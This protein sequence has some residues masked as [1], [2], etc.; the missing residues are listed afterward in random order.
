MQNIQMAAAPSAVTPNLFL[1]ILQNTLYEMQSYLCVLNVLFTYV[2]YLFRRLYLVPLIQ[3]LPVSR[4]VRTN[5]SAI[6]TSCYIYEQTSNSTR[7]G[8]I[9]S[10]RG[11]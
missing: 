7:Q 5:V 10:R 11:L 3:I 9:V 4:C 8:K 2:V 6:T 1:L